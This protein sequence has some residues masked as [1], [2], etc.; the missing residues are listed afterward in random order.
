M[1]TGYAFLFVRRN[2]SEGFVGAGLCSARG[3]DPMT[4]NIDTR[5]GVKTPPYKVT[6][7]GIWRVTP[8]P[9]VPGPGQTVTP[10]APSVAAMTALI[11]CIRFSAS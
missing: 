1:K 7:N 8:G 6:I 2:S 11:V 3:V 10:Y 4:G 5:G 9:G